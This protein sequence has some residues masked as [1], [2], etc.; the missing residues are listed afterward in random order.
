MMGRK[1][2]VLWPNPITNK[3]RQ[4]Q[5]CSTARAQTSEGGVDDGATSDI[6][7]EDTTDGKTTVF[8]LQPEVTHF[9]QH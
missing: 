3:T 6:T 7:E 1:Q 2:R 9:K 5:T 4:F 8:A